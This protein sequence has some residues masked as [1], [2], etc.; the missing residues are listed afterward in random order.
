MV[1]SVTSHQALEGGGYWL[2]PVRAL[3]CKSTQ[4]WE[5]GWVSGSLPGES[6]NQ[7]SPDGRPGCVRKERGGGARAPLV[8]FEAEEYTRTR[9]ELW[10]RTAG[11][12]GLE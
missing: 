3:G 2:R 5:E 10:G 12:L 9:E 1:P 4:S 7:L 8:R 6:G 11:L